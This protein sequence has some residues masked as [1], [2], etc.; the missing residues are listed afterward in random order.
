MALKRVTLFAA[1]RAS[2]EEH[3][4][5]VKL[6]QPFCDRQDAVMERM[7]SIPVQ[8]AEGRRAK[9]AVL[10]SCLLGEDWLSV[11]T[12]T[13]YSLRIARKL[14]IE[15]VEVS[16]ARCCA[17]GSHRCCDGERIESER[18]LGRSIQR[19]RLCGCYP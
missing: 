13:A 14:L 10:L 19:P 3:E 5:L 16:L 2:T 6:Q 17:F 8:M 15:F 9:V 18:R 7:F 1:A 4:R 11:D 12:E